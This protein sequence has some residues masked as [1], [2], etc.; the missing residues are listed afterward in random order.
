MAVTELEPKSSDVAG[1]PM[2]WLEAEIC[3]LA[4]HIAAAT[5]R[6]LLLVGEMDRRGGWVT[7][8]CSSCAHWLSWR[9][10]MS[11]RTARDH[12][13]VARALEHLPVMTAA[14]GAGQLS[15]SKVRAMTRVATP[16]SETDLVAVAR[17]GTASHI[18]RIVA[19]YRQVERNMDPDRARAQLRGRGVWYESNDDGSVTI[20]I[21]GGP[22]AIARIKEAIAAAMPEVPKLVDEPGAPHAARRFDAFEHVARVYLEPDEH[23]APRTETVIHADL[24][25]LTE[26]QPGRA[27]LDDGT[28]LTR[29]VLQ[30]LTCD[31]GL[32]LAHDRRGQTLDIGRRSRTIPPA[33]RRAILDR[34][35]G[36]CRF[37]GCTH[38]GRLQIHHAKHWSRNGHTKQA[39]LILVCLYH[40]KVLHEG[41]WHVTGDADGA[42]TFTD[43]NGRPMREVSLPPPRTDATA[44]RKEHARAGTHISAHTITAQWAGERLDL[45]HA[46]GALWH[47]DPPAYN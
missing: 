23:A 36:T 11:L 29:D 17:H 16:K 10:G 12:V 30:R 47:L 33:L 31:S 4:G 1:R 14:F 2:E 13:R 21:R 28:S 6:F 24:E 38:R 40:H 15:Y 37:P 26:D 22:D 35:R 42:L 44:I 3:T 7:W 45:D 43:P 18:D 9:C 20:T 25:T 39:N 8:E 32:R 41:G 19:G 34:D 46:V 27:E 5:C